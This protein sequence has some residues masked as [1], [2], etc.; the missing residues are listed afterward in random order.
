V[1]PIRAP[2]IAAGELRDYLESVAVVDDGGTPA[3]PLVFVDLSAGLAS[4]RREATFEALNRRHVVA[5][6]LAGETPA[7]RSVAAALAFTVTAAVPASPAEIA[8]ADLDA[9]IELIDAAIADC[10]QA[11]VTLADLL[12]LTAR[13]PV[14]EAL[15]AE[16]MAYSMLLGGREFARWLAARGRRAPVVSAGPAVL[17]E[18]VDQTLHVTINR[19]D[20]HNAFDRFVRDGLAEAFDLARL[21]ESIAHVVLAGRGASFCSG[22]DLAE[23]GSASDV[24]T[25]HVVRT[26]RS[27]A[28]RLD[29]SRAKVTARLHGA[30]IGAG[31][32]IPSFASRV[33]A[34]DDVRIRLPELSM[35]LVPG[36]GGTVGITRRIGRWR[37]AFLAVTGLSIGL[38]TATSWG[39]VDERVSG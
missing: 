7:D 34:S 37:T 28:A 6:G 25:A 4:D 13:L 29:S 38:D 16:S 19:P 33:C 14:R 18:R 17:L 30:C 31:I 22:G 3:A 10:P 39:L 8:V 23:F 20:R 35:G 36:A 24:A 15:T 21:D 2:V 26:D 5:V 32:E 11:A 9:T 12:H 27:V 1:S